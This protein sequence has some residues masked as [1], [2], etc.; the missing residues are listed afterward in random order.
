M[1]AVD[2]HTPLVV[3]PSPWPDEVLYSWVGTLIRRNALSIN[4]WASRLLLG[5]KM[6]TLSMDLP[7][8]LAHLN[9]VLGPFSGITSAS[10]LIDR[11]TLYPYHRPFV[12]ASRDSIITNVMLRSDLP[13]SGLKTLLGRVAN[14]F[15]A[16]TRLRFCPVC[17]ATDIER[18]G[19]GYL[20]SPDVNRCAL[21]RPYPSLHW[22]V[23]A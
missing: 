1:H 6:R 3:A 14:R 11:T 19:E 18:F 22:P 20:P 17:V 15:G 7:T 23:D 12:D 5:G 2:D 13:G 9:E 16:H 21:G 8:G 4:Q 10:D